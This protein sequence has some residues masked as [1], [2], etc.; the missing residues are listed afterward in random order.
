MAT[1]TVR[2]V[3][4]GDSSGA[5]AA[6]GRL[7]RSFGGLGRAAKVAGGAVATTLVVALGAAVKSAIDFERAMRN[8]NS[9]AKLSEKEFQRLSKRVLELAGETG[10]APKTLAEGLYDIVSSG[11][12]ANDAIKVLAAS[13]KAATAGLTDTRTAARAVA[14]ALNAY[15]LSA[16]DARKVSDILFQTVN[17]GVLTFEEL[18]QNMG[19]LVPAAAPLG[20]TLEE[21]G[22]AIAT[23]TLQGVP[24]AEAA[25]RVKNTMIQL[26]SPSK[27]LAALL[28]D[29]GYA[30]GEA[31]VEAEG[32]VGVLRLLDQATQGSVTKTA[33]LTPEIRALLGIVGL[34]GE[35]IKT[36][37]S[38]LEAMTEA[39]D[40]AGAT[41]AAFAEQAKSV[42]FQWQQAKVSLTAAAIPLAQL[43]FP[44]LVKAAE[45]TRVL[46]E[47]MTRA[48]PHIQRLVEQAMTAINRVWEQH[49]RQAFESARR[50]TI[51][52][53]QVIQ[54]V[55]PDIR[56]TVISAL[57][58]MEPAFQA[59]LKVIRALAPAVEALA[60]VFVVTLKVA[61][62][63]VRV[64]LKAIEIFF[65]AL[66]TAIDV[67]TGA[68]NALVSALR[69]LASAISSL[70]SLPS[71][72]K[73]PS[74]NP[75]R[76][77]GGAVAAGRRYIVGE[78]GME[79]FVP[80]QSGFVVPNDMLR[81]IAAAAPSLQGMPLAGAG[82][83]WP[84]PAGGFGGGA[85][86]VSV[87]VA[88]KLGADLEGLARFVRV[89]AVHVS[90]EIGAAIGRKADLRA[91][92]GG[93]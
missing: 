8:V 24:A 54:A 76:A 37:N 15:H 3:F 50:L 18:A 26:A 2:V 10:Q 14:A 77:E 39:T 48:M 5:T 25:T 13:A 31:A 63:T 60:P 75:F 74:L 30:S 6:M 56:A 16:D 45:A 71:L 93:F 52:L 89:E 20:V 22:A 57:N 34:T 61:L 9:I 4:L 35:N 84:V 64:Q 68:V 55:W 1:S 79:L 85:G 58:A 73:I 78:R 70:P 67:V 81:A 87:D 69:A 51:V 53:G 42:A 88:V 83:G 49:G 38:N 91:R 72:P 36:Y 17:K 40:G 66:G 59:L 21:V 27:A 32:F 86:A 46:A 44:A 43:L 92:A 65:R 82:G 62:A 11:F 29:A 23:I 41:S 12:D 90:D 7:D 47:A 80:S 33:A 28:R 19:D